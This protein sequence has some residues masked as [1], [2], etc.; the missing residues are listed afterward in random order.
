[1]IT[2]KYPCICCG[3]RII[4]SDFT[5]GFGRYACVIIIQCGPRATLNGTTTRIGAEYRQ[6]KKGLRRRVWWARGNGSV[7]QWDG[8]WW[9]SVGDSSAFLCQCSFV[10]CLVFY[11]MFR[12][13]SL[14]QSL[15][16]IIRA[17]WNRK[18]NGRT[19]Y[20]TQHNWNS[21]GFGLFALVSSICVSI[22]RSNFKFESYD[23]VKLYKVSTALLRLYIK[24]ND[25][26]NNNN[27]L[28]K[29]MIYY[30][31]IDINLC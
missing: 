13:L 2:S 19:P 17:L 16:P 14:S 4:F 3:I 30:F 6:K 12:S 10:L 23:K 21:T 7:K 29:F 24:N 25:N 9:R 18:Q 5:N 26:N 28:K 8:W 15:S 1:M 11:S 20:A 27:N 31:F 22:C